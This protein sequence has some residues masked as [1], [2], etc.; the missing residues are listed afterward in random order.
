MVGGDVVGDGNVGIYKVASIEDAGPGEITFLANP[1][2]HRHL[3]GCRASAI[4]VAPG[5]AARARNDALCQNYLEA[6]DPYS[7]FAKIH[8]IFNPVPRPPAGVSPWAHVDA[9]AS[10]GSDVTIFPC[11]FVSRGAR[12]GARTV[13]YPGVFLGDDVEIGDDCALHPNV[14][15]RHGCKVGNRVIIHAGAVIGSDG[16]G[17]AGRGDERVKIP[18]AGTVEIHDDVEIGAN[19]A[20]DRATFGSTVIGRGAKLDNLVQIAHNVAVGEDSIIAAQVGIAGSTRI[21][22]NVILAGQAGVVNHLDIGDGA[23]IGPQS[24]VGRS[25]PK[26]AKVSSGLHAAPHQEW[27]KVMLLLPRLPELWAL[28]RR[29]ERKISE[30]LRRSEKG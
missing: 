20:V 13:L 30:L 29:L 7:A 2:Y 8:R 10:L 23:V 11:V 15:V 1:R 24:G 28:T 16:F 25:V 4:I 5:V 18:Q 22:R 26:G 6:P 14:V 17:Y 9:Q 21:G 19:A 3:S 12:V 27:L